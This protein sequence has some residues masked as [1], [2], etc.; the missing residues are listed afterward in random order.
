[1][2]TLPV[3]VTIALLMPALA[4]QA[5]DEG[6]HWDYLGEDGAVWVPDEPP[7]TAALPPP[8]LGAFHDHAELTAALQALAAAHPS[9]VTLASLGDSVEGRALWSLTLRAHADDAKPGVLFDGAHHGDE[10]IASEILYRYAEQLVAEYPATER[11]RA[12]LD[13]VNLV[14]VPM[15][16]PDGVAQAHTATNY[17]TARKNANGVDLNRNYA[18]TWGGTGSSGSPGD[19]TYRGP[20]PASEPE[21]RAIQ[22]LM[23]SRGW[24]FYSSLHSG[25]EMILWPYGHTTQSPP[26]LAMYTR[27][28]D[29]LS[30]RT[31]APDG[32]VSKILY[33][34]SGDSMDHAYIAGAEGWKPVATSPEVFEGSGNAFD[35]WPLFNPSDAAIPTHVARWTA[36][37][38]HLARESVH[39]APPALAAPPPY[40][41]PGA[42]FPVATSVTTPL[43]R[44]FVDASATATAPTFLDITTANPIALGALNGTAAL[45]WTLAPR[46]GG[47]G[48][49]GLRVAAGIAGNL[50][51]SV[52]VT[53]TA[54]AIHLALDRA[55][56]G[57]GETATA[58]VRATSDAPLEGTATL[59]WRGVA[60]DTRAVALDGT[61]ELTWT[62]DVP[63]ADAP[64]GGQPVTAR[65]TYGDGEV[66]ATQTLG[67]D[68]PQLALTRLAPASA[69]VGT[70]FHMTLVAKNVGN[71]AARNVTLTETLPLGYALAPRDVGVPLPV[72]PLA[73]PAPKE[74]A[75]D[76]EGR[77]TLTWQ[78]VGLAAGSTFAYQLR[79]V[80]AVAGEHALSTAVAYGAVYAGGRGYGYAE[81]SASPQ[82]VGLG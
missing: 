35:W 23:A 10:V 46:S 37:L 41:G 50:T 33:S 14:L 29:E 28:G 45:A 1:M 22:T 63:V 60:L 24:T 20:S 78:L 39:Y 6:G 3:L 25:A 30:A 42:P 44:P 58:T 76:E 69:S 15:V 52:P 64:A 7:T 62:V 59:E 4:A 56:A 48:V 72:D 75:V 19:A 65:M 43:K 34:V 79:L 13:E 26:E 40:V 21:T 9:L 57:S 82:A 81:T 27:L 77:V 31:G 80:P 38:D 73:R 36:F 66:S 61:N 74:I 8:G 67:I 47:E 49:I 53:I 54:P 18:A 11:S 51:A 55:R 5:A 2:R 17:A 32:Q 68:R 16:N 12:I 70:P 71:M